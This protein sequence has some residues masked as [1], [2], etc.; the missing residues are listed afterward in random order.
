MFKHLIVKRL[1]MAYLVEGGLDPNGLTER[2]L[3]ELIEDCRNKM[4][5]LDELNH[6]INIRQRN[7]ATIIPFPRRK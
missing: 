3:E 6:I 2:E 1:S 5:V 4:P 7:K